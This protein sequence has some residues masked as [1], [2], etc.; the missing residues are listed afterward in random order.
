MGVRLSAQ[1]L[2]GSRETMCP[3]LPRT[4]LI[5]K[6]SLASQEPLSPRQTRQLVPLTGRH[7][8]PAEGRGVFRDPTDLAQTSQNSQRHGG[9]LANSVL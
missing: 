8:H 4:N 1:G 3:G 6:L 5:L 2:A 9:L 7:L